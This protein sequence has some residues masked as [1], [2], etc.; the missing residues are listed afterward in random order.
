MDIEIIIYLL[1]ILILIVMSGF[2]SGTETA[3]T[4]CSWP[5]IHKLSKEGDK[6]AKLVEE[7]R[8]YKDKMIGAILLGN[9]MVNILASALATGLFIKIVGDAGVFYATIVMTLTVLIFAEV[10]PKTYAFYSADK[11]AMAVSPILR[12]VIYIFS[13]ITEMISAIVKFVLRLFGADISRV[14]VG[15]HIDVLRGAIELH[16]GPEQETTDQRAMLRSILDLAEVE[17]GEIMAHR[18]NV[19]MIDADGSNEKII[20]QVLDSPYTR[21]PVYRGDQDNIIGV[22]HAKWLLRELKDQGNNVEN[23]NIDNVASDPWFIPETTS[24]YDQLQAFRKRREHF[25]LVVDE[26]GSFM[27][28]VTLE[29]ILEEI[30]GDI[31]DEHDIAVAGVRKLSSGNYLVDG[32]VTIRDLNREFEWSLPDEEYSTV[33]G[34]VLYE[35]KTI[36]DAGQSYNFYGFRFDIVRRQRNQIAMVKITPP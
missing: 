1:A 6:R 9:N 13:P 20:S 22:I 28:I 34:L 21:L 16:Q 19:I 11:M 5:R 2:F 4:A 14:N 26:Y 33:A 29:D 10:L 24:L 18:K 30:V 27:G 31:D 36:P 25:A 7:I 15:D 23:I 35:A 17:V 8:E 3:F 32:T 12:I